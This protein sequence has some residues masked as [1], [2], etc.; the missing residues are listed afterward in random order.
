MVIYYGVGQSGSV[1]D[2]DLRVMW[3]EAGKNRFRGNERTE[4]TGLIVRLEDLSRF[5]HIFL[6]PDLYGHLPFAQLARSPNI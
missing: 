1:V 2:R 4:N 5:F 6:S 3:P